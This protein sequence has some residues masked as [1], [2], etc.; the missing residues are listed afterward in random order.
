[1]RWVREGDGL[2]VGNI[3]DEGYGFGDRVGLGEG[4]WSRMETGWC[5]EVG[6]GTEW[7]L[8]RETG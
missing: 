8:G 5:V 3:F 6:F 4:D 1:M 2:V 7:G